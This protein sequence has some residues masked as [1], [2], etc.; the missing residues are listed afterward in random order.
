MVA[1]M[2][3]QDMVDSI[4]EEG[5][6]MDTERWVLLAAHCLQ[7]ELKRHRSLL[8]SSSL[9]E[10]SRFDSRRTMTKHLDLAKI[11]LQRLRDL[12]ELP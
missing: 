10:G 8:V 6:G 11:A 4:A 2:L 5:A 12:L 3:A 7:S 9:I 1:A